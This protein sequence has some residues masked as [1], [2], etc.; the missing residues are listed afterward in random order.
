MDDVDEFIEVRVD[1]SK[2]KKGRLGA[3][4]NRPSKSFDDPTKK[5]NSGESRE[6]MLYAIWEIL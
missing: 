1:L 5:L 6:G 3:R 4:A 2:K